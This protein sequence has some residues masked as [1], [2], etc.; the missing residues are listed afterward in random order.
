MINPSKAFG[1]PFRVALLAALAALGVARSAHADITY[2]PLVAKAMATDLNDP[3]YATC[4]PQC[5]LCH[6]TI[7][8]G[9]QML[10]PFG[11]TMRDQGG[12][13]TSGLASSVLPALQKLKMLDPDSDGDG[14]PDFEELFA[15]DSPAIKGAAGVGAICGANSAAPT[16]GCGARIAAP[17]P[18]DRLSLFS[19][20]L[21]VF[22]LAAARRR[23]AALRARRGPG[24]T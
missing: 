11:T 3:I 8:G 13:S 1:S 5:T 10:N 23:R 7:A 4:T 18:V 20:G 16:Y 9:P 17:P 22:G 2:P 21:V 14:I 6:L 19:A 15:G 24:P 12:L